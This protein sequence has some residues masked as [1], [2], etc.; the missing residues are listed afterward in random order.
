[1]HK[2]TVRMLC[3]LRKNFVFAAFKM[4]KESSCL[5]YCVETYHLSDSNG[6]GLFNTIFTTPAHSSLS[7]ETFVTKDN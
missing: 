3:I 4:K 6:D 1:M 5:S 7:L 2:M